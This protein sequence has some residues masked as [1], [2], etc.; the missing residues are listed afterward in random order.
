M[1]PSADAVFS[2][3][4]LTRRVWPRIFGAAPLD[5]GSRAARLAAALQELGGLYAAFARFLCWRADLLPSDYLLALRE[6]RE[7]VPPVPPDDFKL[8]LLA[9]LGTT[10]KVLAEA[11]EKE[12][13]W[14]T[15][16]RCAYRSQLRGETVVV[17]VAREPVSDKA[18]HAFSKAVSNL[19]DPHLRRAVAAGILRQ[20]R[21]WLNLGRTL[22]RE[23]SFLASIAEAGQSQVDYPR[24]IVEGCGRRVLAWNWVDAVPLPELI[25]A[26]AGAPALRKVAEC[27]MEQLCI[28]AVAE[29]ELDLDALAFTREGKLVVRRTN[30]LVP[31]PRSALPSVLKY[32]AAVL[33]MDAPAAAH[34]LIQLAYSKPKPDL[35]SNLAGRLSNLEPELKINRRFPPSAS[36]FESNWRGLSGLPVERP[37]FLDSMHRNLVALGYWNSEVAPAEGPLE[38][39]IADAQWNTISGMLQRRASSLLD[40]KTFSEW[41][42]GTGMMMAEGLRQVNRIG[43]SLRDND[44]GVRVALDSNHEEQAK[45]N[46]AL[47][48]SILMGLLLAVFLLAMHYAT[49]LPAPFSTWVTAVAFAA[50]GGALWIL[51]RLG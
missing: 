23:R 32:V 27:V 2:K 41:T 39:M 8:M 48:Q 51:L 50:A 29:T 28:L 38:D 20:F 16:Q 13:C 47:R 18:F 6:V 10:G 44:L 4:E 49:R 5:E 9:D 26:G 30:R 42:V 36:V 22:E 7:S 1:T 33:K 15:F 11:L 17:Q 3:A 24:L 46:L 31:V 40:G 45:S 43:K 21:E 35:E 12:P 14:S 25:G 37:L 34:Q 19:D